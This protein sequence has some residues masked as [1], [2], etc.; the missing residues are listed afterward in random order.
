MQRISV[1]LPE[2]DGPQRTIFSPLRTVRLMSFSAWKLPYH[3]STDSIWI[4]GVLASVW[5][6]A[7]FLKGQAAMKGTPSIASGK[8]AG[9]SCFIQVV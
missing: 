2:P 8:L 7:G 3:F 4:N 6:M 1:D 5:V 9:G